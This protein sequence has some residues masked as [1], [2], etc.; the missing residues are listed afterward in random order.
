MVRHIYKLTNSEGETKT[1][2]GIKN[3]ASFLGVVVST[4]CTYA[5]NGRELKGWKIEEI[6][7]DSGNKVV[8]KAAIKPRKR[9][10]EDGWCFDKFFKDTNV[11]CVSKSYRFDFDA[12]INY[13]KLKN[14]L[15]LAVKRLIENDKELDNKYILYIKIPQTDYYKYILDFIQYQLLYFE[16]HIKFKE[17]KNFTE[18]INHIKQYTNKIEEFIYEYISNREME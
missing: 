7:V 5:K 13:E 14:L 12:E 4:I 11:C 6:V 10:K 18:E 9:Y 15:Q 2:D 8:E 1:I 3:A 17:H 16:L